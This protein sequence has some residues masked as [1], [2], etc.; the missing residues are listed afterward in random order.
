MSLFG[1]LFGG[2][3]L[4]Q[5][6]AEADA[7]FERRDF[8]PA[9]L[10]YERAASL[11]KA[12]PELQAQLRTRAADCQNEIAKLHLVEAERL[13]KEGSLD[14]AF[15]E[16]RQA[17]LTAA[18]PALQRQ[19]HERMEALERVEVRAEVAE[20][21]A[22]NEEDRFELIAGGFEDDQYA[23]YLANGDAVK[24]ALL[25]LHDGH[26]AQARAQLEELLKTADGP[27]YLWFELGRARLADNDAE[28]GQQALE[29]FLSTLHADEGGDARLLARTELAQLAHARGDTEG[30]VAHYEAALEAMPDDPRPYLAM[31]GF[32][33]QEKLLDEAIE[34]LEAGLEAQQDR[35]PDVRFWQELGLTYADQ[36]ND[37][38][39]IKWLERVLERFA[40]QRLT[41]MPPEGTLKLAELHERAGRNTRALDL[42][43]L[44]ARGSDLPRLFYY[45][46]QAARLLAASNLQQEARRMLVR[47]LELAPD[48][49]EINARLQAALQL[50]EAGS[51]PGAPATPAANP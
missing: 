30:A 43:S 45:H 26:T 47:A 2:R 44:L 19:A 41:D 24:Q 8:G 33:R 39:A 9:K 13:A 46:E 16:L 23:E 11:A 31:A 37:A 15:E 35:T 1:K 51:A 50:A 21:T 6:R 49:A 5:E 40:S 25:S 36:G 34:V 17:G 42:Y 29:K 3:T 7:L 22:P 10:S 14:L 27:R 28:G 12:Q 48:N 18:D 20:H 4:E 38:D 32:F